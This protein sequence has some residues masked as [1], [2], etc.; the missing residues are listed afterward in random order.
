MKELTTKQQK[1]LTERL[2]FLK[3]KRD[4]LK[5]IKT[6]YQW[7]EASEFISTSLAQEDAR[8]KFDDDNY[9][10]STIIGLKYAK[11]KMESVC[12]LMLKGKENKAAYP[13]WDGI[14]ELMR[15]YNDVIYRLENKV[16]LKLFFAKSHNG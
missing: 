3:H 9:T 5:E 16:N 12:E 2:D 8:L 4:K 15:D 1:L 13:F 14:N 11:R 7:E 10:D 6:I